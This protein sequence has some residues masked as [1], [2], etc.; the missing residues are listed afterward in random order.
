MNNLAILPYV[1]MYALQNQ[2]VKRNVAKKLDVNTDALLNEK[3]KEKEEEN[4]KGKE[5]NEKG[6][7]EKEEKEGKKENKNEKKKKN[8]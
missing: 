2:N 4:E 6:K 1:G 3:E 7:E 5:E 8:K